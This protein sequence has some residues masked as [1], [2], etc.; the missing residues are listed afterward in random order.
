MMQYAN[1]MIQIFKNIDEN[2]RNS[3]IAQWLEWRPSETA[4]VG[5]STG[6][7]GTYVPV[8]LRRSTS[9]QI[10]AKPGAR[11]IKGF[12]NKITRISAANCPKIANLVPS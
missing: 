6:R 10:K 5:W 11:K 12:T 8:T 7:G 9:W 2:L 1:N 3:I 4:V